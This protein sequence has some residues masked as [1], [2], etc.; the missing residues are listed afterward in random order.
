VPRIVTYLI[1]LAVGLTCLGAALTAWRT[2]LRVAAV[3]LFVAGAAA[4]AH[5][6]LS[7]V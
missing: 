1:E 4:A 7:L 3:V 5:A 6:M 2:G